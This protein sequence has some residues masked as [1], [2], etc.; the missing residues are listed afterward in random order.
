VPLIIAGPGI[1]H[2]IN[3]GLASNL[4]IAPTIADLTGVTPPGPFDG[5]S[6]VPALDGTGRIKTKAVLLEHMSEKWVRSYC[7]LRTHRWKYIL[8]RT[9]AEELYDLRAD[10][11][12]LHNVATSDPRVRHRLHA[13]TLAAC[14]PFP[15]DWNT[16]ASP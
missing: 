2:G 6:L 13:R 9:G 1:E 4:D 10:P 7:G 3:H 15:P 5:T 16:S 8:Y 12:E 14:E 11:Y